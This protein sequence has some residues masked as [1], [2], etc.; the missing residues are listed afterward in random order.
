MTSKGLPDLLQLQARVSLYL[1]TGYALSTAPSL[2]LCTSLSPCPSPRHKLNSKH[3]SKLSPDYVP[4]A[5]FVYKSWIQAL[6]QARLSLVS[7]LY[8]QAQLEAR[9]QGGP[10]LSPST[11]PGFKY[12]SKCPVLIYKFGS[13]YASNLVPDSTLVVLSF[14]KSWIQVRLQVW[15]ALVPCLSPACYTVTALK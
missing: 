7:S 14:P 12:G 5:L 2:A 4:A 1:S 3:V 10:W 11:I 13:K 8:L 15:P 9:L 6:L